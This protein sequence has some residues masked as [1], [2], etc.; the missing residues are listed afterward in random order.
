MC[1]IFSVSLCDFF[2]ADFVTWETQKTKA[3]WKMT[4]Y[5]KERLYKLF[6]YLE[7]SMIVLDEFARWP[8]EDEF[9]LK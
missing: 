1:G 2:R 3:S 5:R 4:T 9:K 7:L 8:V 6:Q